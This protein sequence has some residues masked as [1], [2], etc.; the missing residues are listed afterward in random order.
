MFKASR[1][2]SDSNWQAERTL[3]AVLEFHFMC[4]PKDHK[5]LEF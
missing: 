1:V 3:D 5:F 2:G 4:E